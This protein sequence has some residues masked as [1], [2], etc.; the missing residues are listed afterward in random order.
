MSNFVALK[1]LNNEWEQHKHFNWY[2][3]KRCNYECS[4][5]SDMLHDKTSKLPTLEELKTA[6]NNIFENIPPELCFFDFTGGEPCLIKDFVPFL[7]WLKEE[8]NIKR[9]GCISNGSMPYAFYDKLMQWNDHI[10][11]S[12]HFEYADDQI[13]TDKVIQLHKKYGRKIRVQIMYHAKHYPRVKNI[14]EQIREAGVFFSIREI[15]EKAASPD[16]DP[17]AMAYTEE[18]REWMKANEPQVTQKMF[19]VGL[20]DTG[21]EIELPSGNYMIHHRYNEFK[22]WHCWIGLDYFQIWFDGTINRGGC[23]VGESLGNVYESVNWPTEP[24]VCTKDGCFC[25]PEI[26]SRKTKD[27]KNKDWLNVSNKG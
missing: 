8:K 26:F 22:G 17:D 12:Y 9:V 21:E 3:T 4:Y 7:Q 24:V 16:F 14:V 18:M 27:L 11:I 23:G 15:R 20:T 6:A 1:R 5:C 19:G 2:I 10:T 25:G 13:L